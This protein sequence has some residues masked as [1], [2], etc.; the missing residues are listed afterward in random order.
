MVHTDKAIKGLVNFLDN[1]LIPNLPAKG[2][3]RPV[4]GTVIALASQRVGKLVE[5]LKKNQMLV[6]IG[7]FDDSGMVDIDALKTE[8]SKQLGSDGMVI[9]F[10]LIG[11]V[12]FHQS[13]V[14]K[15]Y[16]YIMNA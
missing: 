8:F 2:W 10:P 4:C 7:I 3:Q 11:P 9:E 12:T 1:E 14:D 6:G 5:G 13:D 15:L 16:S